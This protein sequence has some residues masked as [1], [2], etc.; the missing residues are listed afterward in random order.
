MALRI[1]AALALFSVVAACQPGD[2]SSEH[3][4]FTEVRN[5]DVRG[6][7]R[8]LAEGG[9][10]N[11]VNSDGDT[12]LYVASGAK[13]GFEVV[14]VLLLAG[15]DTAKLS[16]ENRTPLHTAAAWCNERIV[17]ALLNEGAS[18]TAQNAEGQTPPQVVCAQPYERRDQVLALFSRA[19]WSE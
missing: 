7:Q 6:V 11:L 3:P 18:F 2:T 14:E 9:D 16:R 13:G 10:P 15:A 17:E 4:V 1:L 12:M 19:G 8:Y 5:N